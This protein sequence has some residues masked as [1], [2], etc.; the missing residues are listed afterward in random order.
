[1]K[2]FVKNLFW[3]FVRSG[4]EKIRPEDIDV[5]IVPMPAEGGAKFFMIAMAVHFGR[6]TDIITT[7]V[8]S[9][10]E[11]ADEWVK[12]VME[13]RSWVDNDYPPDA[14]DRGEYNPE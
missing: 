14:Y 12:I 9:S 4:L 3:R 2:A 5:R 10:L 6:R 8:E 13:N 11:A 7:A 1:M